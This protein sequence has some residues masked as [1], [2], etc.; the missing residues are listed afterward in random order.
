M[1]VIYQGALI[2]ILAT[3]GMDLWAAF[4]K[5]VLHLPTTHWN[6]V[7]RWF[8][9]LP[10]G[11]FFHHPIA[12][13]PP[14]TNELAIGWIAHYATGIVYGVAYLAIVQLLLS[15][16][17]SLGSALLFGLVTLVA[18]WLIMQPGMGLGVFAIKAPKPGVTRL[19]NL[20]M[21]LVFG[22]CL[23]AGWLML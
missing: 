20:S 21:H 23:Y 6:M 7:G 22:A 16:T 18:P 2:G 10:R 8:A 12:N 5:H 1:E 4:A 17:P 14:V 19:V 3:I 13:S 9:H 15:A 11:K